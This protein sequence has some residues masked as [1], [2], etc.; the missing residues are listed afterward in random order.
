MFLICIIFQMIWKNY[1]VNLLICGFK[2]RFLSSMMTRN[3]M[4]FFSQI[5]LLIEILNVAISFLGLFYIMKLVLLQLIDSL[6]ALI[7]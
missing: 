4:S 7:Q 3:F 5:S 2:L 1:M 6:L